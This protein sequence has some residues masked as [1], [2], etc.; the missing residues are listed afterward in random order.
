LGIAGRSQKLG[1]GFGAL[2]AQCVSLRFAT[3]FG[4]RFGEIGEQHRKPQPED[5]LEFEQDMPAA[6]DEVA[7]QDHRREGGNNFQN[8]H[9]RVLDQRARIKLHKGGADRRHDDLRIEQ[10][11]YRHALAEG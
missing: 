3:A 10:R 8:E 9:H 5:D 6:R 2:A 4:D 1:L 7:D 11:R